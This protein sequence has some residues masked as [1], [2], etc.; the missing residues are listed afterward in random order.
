MMIIIEKMELLSNINVILTNR[1]F[2]LLSY[3]HF[4]ADTVSDPCEGGKSW[5]HRQ[6][7]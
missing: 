5:E 1:L 3:I 6:L 7:E 2:F 4:Q